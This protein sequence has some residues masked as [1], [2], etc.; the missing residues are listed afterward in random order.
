MIEEL[1]PCPICG[2]AAGRD[3]DSDE[4]EVG[5]LDFHCE[6]YGSVHEI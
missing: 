2:G 5:C 6:A 4:G 3:E 1:L